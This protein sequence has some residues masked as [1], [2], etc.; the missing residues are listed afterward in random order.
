MHAAQSG[1]PYG[2]DSKEKR[3]LAAGPCTDYQAIYKL[4]KKPDSKSRCCNS[5]EV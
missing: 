1:A 5:Y 3:C 4:T 2:N